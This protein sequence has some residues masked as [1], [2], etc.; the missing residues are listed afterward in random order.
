MFTGVS[1]SLYKR[2]L[3]FLNTPS[4]I[5]PGS[6]YIITWSGST[7]SAVTLDLLQGSGGSLNIVSTLG[8]IVP[9]LTFDIL[10][11]LVQSTFPTLGHL[12]GQ[13]L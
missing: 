3:A 2:A 7:A 4:T 8:G 12:N 6:T 13:Y 5:N 11:H 10:T 9:L 1:H